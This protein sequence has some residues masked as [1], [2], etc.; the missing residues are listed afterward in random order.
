[1]PVPFA[2]QLTPFLGAHW[3]VMAW[4]AMGTLGLRTFGR[5]GAWS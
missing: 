4:I 1:M 5:W 2:N 3:G